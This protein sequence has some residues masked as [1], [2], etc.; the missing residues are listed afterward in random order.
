[1]SEALGRLA[2]AVRQDRLQREFAGMER[3]ME[4]MPRILYLYSRGYSVEDIADKLTG[5]PTVYGIE[6]TIDIAASL[7]AEQL[8][9]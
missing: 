6:R 9:Q 5:L 2:S 3:Y 8:N 4:R 1:M 7:V